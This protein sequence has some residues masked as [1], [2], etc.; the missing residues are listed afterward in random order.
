[1]EKLNELHVD[2]QRLISEVEKIHPCTILVGKRGEKAQNAAFA[3]GASKLVFPQ[4]SHNKD[5]SDGVDLCPLPIPT[6]V[7]EWNDVKRFYFFGGIVVAVANRLGIKIRWGGDWD[8]DRDLNDQTFMD[9]VH[10]ERILT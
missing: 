1:M 6:N 8:S 7:K 2:L 3:S 9:L 5:P 4:S 10:Y